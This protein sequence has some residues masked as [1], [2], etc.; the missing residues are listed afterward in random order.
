M[1]DR[2]EVLSPWAEVDPEPLRGITPRVADLAGRTIGLFCNSK[3]LARPIITIVEEKLKERFPAARFSWYTPINANRYNVL[4]LE[5][6]VNRPIFED[7]LKGVD[8]VVAAVG[9]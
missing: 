5:S 6:E 2:Y 3:G 1:S 4:Q 9:D 8:T 7:W